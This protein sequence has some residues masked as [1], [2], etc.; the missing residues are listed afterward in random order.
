M[1]LG[2]GTRLGTFEITALLGKGGM[3]EVYRARDLRLGR[4]VAIKILPPVFTTDPER[5]KRFEREAQVLASLNHPHIAQ[6][7]GVE[8]ADGTQALVLE[9]VDGPTLADR[10]ARGAIPLDESLPMARQIADA[11]QAAH[12]RG[13]VHRDLKPLNIKLTP[14][15]DIKVLDFGLAKLTEPNGPA[16]VPGAESMSPTITSPALRTG[17]GLLLGTAAYM[18]PEQARGRSVDTRADI[19]AFGCVLFEMLTGQLAF[20]GEDV[21]ETLAAVVRAEP[22][23]NRL[24]AETPTSIRT[25]LRHCLQKDPRRRWQD[26]AS[27]RICIDEASGGQSDVVVER[28]AGGLARARRVAVI[29]L[30]ALAGA[31][32]SAVAVWN[33]PRQGEPAPVTRVTVGVSPARQVARSLQF[34]NARPFRI[35]LAV[36]P[37]G[38]SLVFA[39]ATLERVGDAQDAQGRRQLYLRT[40]D[41]FD[42]TPIPGTEGADSPFFSPDG[43]WVG[44]WQPGASLGDFGELKKAPLGGGP[45]VTLCRTA[46]PG[47]ISW[48]S[49]GRIVFANHAGGGLWHVA[50]TGGM[51]QELTKADPAKGE[52]G[53]RLPFVL[54]GG[55]VV[56]FTIQ[57]SPDSWDGTQIVARSLV[58]GDQKVLVEGGVDARY[59]PSGHLVYAQSG[60][61]VAQPFDVATLEVSGKPTSLVDDVMHD[62]NSRFAVGNSGAAQ[63]SIAGGTLVYLRGGIAP[64]G[65]YSPVWVDRSGT[66][67]EIEVPRRMPASRP[68][69]SPDG[70]RVVFPFMAGI[71][72]FD[73]A[74]ETFQVMSADQ[75][76]SPAAGT[77]SGLYRFAVWHPD[78]Q[79]LAFT[80]EGGNLFSVVADGSGVVEPLTTSDAESISLRRLDIPSSWSSDGKTLAFTRRQDPQTP[81]NRDIWM[82][83]VGNGP[84][85]ARPFLT[86]PADERVAEFSPDGRYVAYQSTQSGQ[87]EIYVQPYPGTG[88][89]VVSTDGGTQPA[90]DRGG[91]ELYYWA[92]GR[93][94]AI[95]MMAVDVVLGNTF[96]VGKPRVLFEK[97][98][99]RFP[100]GLGGR[101]YDVTPDGKRFIMNQQTDDDSQPPI[102]EI[103][104]VQNW[105]EELKRLAPTN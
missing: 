89:Q 35:A 59:V 17:V 43:Q 5:V 62:V 8:D 68:R 23:W 76:R 70:R 30:A 42:A 74:R 45:V 2:P 40:F 81:T 14:D 65:D 12:E 96:A 66:V 3:G 100:Q 16:A 10:V 84:P 11:L 103:V 39:G 33:I 71:G 67:E 20:A 6:I 46:L 13:I 77:A 104:L 28:R 53:H 9:L 64:E 95:R 105:V 49:N 58:T 94:G 52:F 75:T 34:P 29:A 4:E 99:V 41:R 97:P 69:L 27:L 60:T 24:P 86:T 83:S 90:W 7:H 93:N 15:G 18:S 78:G 88:A 79:I 98:S 44:F 1:T 47:G 102:T 87:A 73:I 26:A 85:T 54:P 31:L 63:F 55:E 72:V 101:V 38:R 82:L 50:D 19:W 51:P 36:S 25:L 92:P 61:L 91:R 57:K 32:V 48:G 80:G 56:L 21:T 37:D 22:D